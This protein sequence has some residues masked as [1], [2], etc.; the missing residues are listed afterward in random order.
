MFLVD[1]FE[2]FF[3][4][5]PH[6]NSA[7]YALN[8]YLPMGSKTELTSLNNFSQYIKRESQ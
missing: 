5:F 8:C 6:Q 7:F 2:H 3:H 1:A 4:R